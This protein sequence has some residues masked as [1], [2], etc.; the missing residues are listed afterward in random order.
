MLS[1]KLINACLNGNRK[2]Q[3]EL[4][5][6]YCDA[7]YRVAS[8]YIKDTALAED[9]TQES[10]IKAFA[11]LKTYDGSS[12]FGAWLKQIVINTSIDQL[13]KQTY[14]VSME[15]L[16]NLT[17]DTDESWQVD[18]QIDVTAIIKG[19]D[20]LP[21]KYSVILKLFLMEGYDHE[22]ISEILHI[23]INASRTQLH[24]GKQM[25]KNQLKKQGY[26]RFA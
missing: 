23:S 19:I 20:E 26:E 22:E 2:A 25:L 3:L 14:E 18:D 1:T 6:L 9:V 17:N 8:R 21:F 12:T 4:Y 15:D 7:M 5:S 16:Q 10:F 11:K 24:R 13:R